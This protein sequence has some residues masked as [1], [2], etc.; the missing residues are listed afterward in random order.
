MEDMW[1]ID[2]LSSIQHGR[3][4]G[5]IGVEPFTHGHPD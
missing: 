4:V 2:V 3:T 5:E 1:I